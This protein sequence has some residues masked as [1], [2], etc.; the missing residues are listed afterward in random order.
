MFKMFSMMIL[1]TLLFQSGAS[2]GIAAVKERAQRGDSKAQVQLGIAYASGSGVP[3]DDGE[4]VK[5]FR[6][7]AEKGD[8]A[9]EYSLGEMYLTG[10][11]VSVSLAEAVTWMRRAAKDGDP[12]GQFNL[13]TM[14]AQ[15]VGVP[16]DELKAAK[17][18]LK[19]ADQGLAAGQFGLGAMY[20]HGKG[21]P[22]NA[23]E[24][25]KW[26]RKAGD[27]GDPDALNN[28]ALLLATS[29]DANVRNPREAIVTAQKA[30]DTNGENPAC[31][32]TLA[33]AFYEAGQPDKAA[34]SERRA[35]ALK[36]GDPT[37]KKALDKYVISAK[38]QGR[39]L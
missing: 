12:R 11:G 9:G 39:V 2:D 14:Y 18:M 17:W 23:A 30:V 37:Y 36:P 20:A 3:A 6:R 32:D 10:R 22:Q 4:A 19:A 16:K 38:Q 26:Y 34:E 33:T 29:T 28:L 24:A 27:Q 7:A 8:A 31:L 25:V 1:Y 21:V 13:A 5:W 35:L 15:G